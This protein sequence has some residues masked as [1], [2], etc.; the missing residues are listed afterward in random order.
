MPAED[1]AEQ[2]ALA[3]PVGAGDGQMLAGGQIEIHAI[4]R[5]EPAVPAGDTGEAERGGAR[6]QTS[7]R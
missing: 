2:R 7:G 6:G 4:D 3:R 1:R 5:G